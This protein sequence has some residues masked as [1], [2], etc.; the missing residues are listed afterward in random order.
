MTNY[1]DGRSGG[2]GGSGNADSYIREGTNNIPSLE[3]IP[4]AGLLDKIILGVKFPPSVYIWDSTNTD[5]PTGS[6]IVIPNDIIHP[7]PGRWLLT[8]GSS[9]ASAKVEFIRVPF[10]FNSVTPYIVTSMLLGQSIANSELVIETPF[11]DPNASLTLGTFANP[12]LILSASQ[13][14]PQMSASFGSEVNHLFIIDEFI[15]LFLN[16]LGSTQGS[17][18]IFLE[19]KRI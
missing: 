17:G 6:D 18:Y 10:A 14:K 16:P 15:V 7:D 4:S 13:I 1:V 5:P 19:I 2:V 11:D 9:S 3:A 12:S 8:G